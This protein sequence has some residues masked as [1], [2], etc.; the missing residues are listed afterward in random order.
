NAKEVE[1]AEEEFLHFNHFINYYMKKVVRGS[2]GWIDGFT[3]GE[4]ATSQSILNVL[5]LEGSSTFFDSDLNNLLTLTK[6]I[7]LAQ[8]SEASVFNFIWRDLMSTWD[9]KYKN[10]ELSDGFQIEN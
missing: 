7:M 2:E 3:F 8:I 10:Q 9:N 5:L 1:E 4:I 6:I